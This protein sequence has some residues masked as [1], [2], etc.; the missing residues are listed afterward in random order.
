LAG[1]LVG[2]LTVKA[3]RDAQG[4][5]R[6]TVQTRLAGEDADKTASLAL[7]PDGEVLADYEDKAQ[8]APDKAERVAYVTLASDALLEALDP[9]FYDTV[10]QVRLGESVHLQVI[11]FDADLSDALDQVLVTAKSSKGDQLLVVLVETESHSGVFRGSFLTD[12]GA[13]AADDDLLQTDYAGKIEIVYHDHLR[14][15]RSAG[16][17]RI[18]R[19]DI[20]GGSDGTV[21]GFSRQ[22]RDAT[23]EMKLWYRTGLSAYHI[24]RRLH[25]AGAYEKAEE[26]FIEAADYF[27]QLVSKFPEDALAASANYYL[28]NIQALKSNHREALA[29]FQEVIARWPKSDFVPRARF[30]AG[31]AMEAMGLFDQAADAYVLL[32]YHHPNDEHVPMAMVRMMNHFARLA[33]YLDAVGVAQKFVAKFPKHEQAGAVGLRAGQWLAVAGRVDEA[34]AWFADAE[35][36][37]AASDRDM[38]GILYWHAATLIQGQQRGV[39]SDLRVEKIREL[40]NRIIYDYRDSEYA[41]LARAAIEQVREAMR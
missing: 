8:A 38:P 3:Q 30:K 11:D 33:Q 24:G 37:F 5:Y 23:E 19:L 31:Q 4:L 16:P 39:R 12:A 26:N 18:V 41:N 17:Q 9:H 1:R 15:D 34:L 29:R 36:T 13:A 32:T 40:L 6:A 2:T 10:T 22:F 35:K 21:E 20:P 25:L 27:N 14:L 28:G 7:V